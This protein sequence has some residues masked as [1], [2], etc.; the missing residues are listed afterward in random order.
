M[1]S[2]LFKWRREQHLVSHVPPL[3]TAKIGEDCSARTIMWTSTMSVH[4][5]HTPSCLP[6]THCSLSATHPNQSV[7]V[8][9]DSPSSQSV[10]YGISHHWSLSLILCLSL[11]ALAFLIVAEPTACPPHALSF[12]HPHCLPFPSLHSH[13]P[14]S[15]SQAYSQILISLSRCTNAPV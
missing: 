14:R 10:L 1:W 13:C 4:H 12:S 2:C 7:C 3:H 15:D 5:P 6:F 9:M 8:F 11:T